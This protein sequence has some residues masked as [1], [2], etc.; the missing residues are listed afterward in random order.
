[1]LHRVLAP[2]I[3]IHLAYPSQH[4]L[5]NSLRLG[6]A[7]GLAP[8]PLQYLP[9]EPTGNQFWTSQ[10]YVAFL[11]GLPGN[12]SV[13]ASHL[14]NFGRFSHF[15]PGIHGQIRLRSVLFETR[16]S[17]LLLSL[18]EQVLLMIRFHLSFTTTLYNITNCEVLRSK[19]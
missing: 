15:E 1:M 8:L 19:N 9:G 13:A 17:N 4:Y 3:S 7:A 6:P 14:E 11:Q 18:H 5:Q 16:K 10:S 12:V 2:G